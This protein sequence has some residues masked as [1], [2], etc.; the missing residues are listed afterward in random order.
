M[1]LSVK[2]TKA[3]YKLTLTH[4]LWYK[5]LHNLDT[6]TNLRPVPFKATLL[7]AHV[8][9]KNVQGIVNLEIE[10]K[11]WLLKQSLGGV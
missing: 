11:A 5:S 8:D 10:T 7:W 2:H 1:Q 9:S 6:K 3:K 4:N